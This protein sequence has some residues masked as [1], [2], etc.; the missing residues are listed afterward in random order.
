MD[1]VFV[2]FIDIF[3]CS[4]LYRRQVRLCIV[5][6]HFSV[7]NH[8]NSRLPSELIT[9]THY[10]GGVHNAVNEQQQSAAH[11]KP[12]GLASFPFGSDN[13][14]DLQFLAKVQNILQICPEVDDTLTHILRYE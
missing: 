1:E 8:K 5:R 11:H 3:N 9:G 7:Q 13:P 6:F 4:V 14:Q 2:F 12:Y 10:L